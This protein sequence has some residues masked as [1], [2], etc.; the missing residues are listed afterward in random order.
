M[1]DV[2]IKSPEKIRSQGNLSK[3]EKHQRKA[4]V[5]TQKTPSITQSIADAVVIKNEN[6]FFL[7]LP[8]GHVPMEGNHGFGLY[9]N[10][11]RYLK[12]YEIK[13]ANAEM[14]LLVSDASKGFAAVFE[15]TNPEINLG[16]SN[17]IQAN[18]IGMKVERIID[19][20]ND[21]LYE[22][23]TFQNYGRETFKC[24]LSLQF[25]ADFNDIFA[26]RGLLEQHLGEVEAPAFIEDS[27]RFCYHGADG[28]ERD[29]DVRFSP[30]PDEVEDTKIVFQ[31]DLEPAETKQILV[32]LTVSEA[33]NPDE[34]N[35]KPDNEPSLQGIT[36]YLKR[37]S[38]EWLE[39]H[40]HVHSDSLLLNQ[41]I[42][43]SLRDLR[44]LRNNLDEEEYFAA[45]VPWFTTLFGRDS[46]ITA[47]ETLAY[48]PEIAAE[49]LKLLA[50]YQ[51]TQIDE[52]RDEQ[53]GKIL[54]EIR[55]GELA[56]LGEIPHTP[57]YGSV[58]ATPLFLILIA[59]HADWVGNLDLFNELQESV[60]S[61]LK[62]LT[63]YATGENGFIQYHSASKNGLVNQG[64]KDSGNAIINKDG[65]LA[66]PPIA[67]VEVQGYAYMAMK[68]IA[69]LYNRAGDKAR[70]DFL[71]K[72]AQALYQR[73]N[74]AFWLEDLGYYA[75]A[76]Q[77][78][79]RPCAVV[80]SNPGEALWTGIIEPKYAKQTADRLLAEDMFSGWGVRTLSE[81]EISYNPLGYHLGTVWPHDNALIAAGLRNYGF[82]KQA[83]K[84]FVGIV[85][86][87]MQI[88]FYR[89]PELFAGF[90]RSDY[91]TIVNYPVACHPQ[92]WSAGSIPFLIQEFLGLKP[93]AFEQR[94]R[95]IRP[96]LP[97]FVDRIE[98]H[99]LRVGGAI[100]DLSFERTS[101]QRVAFKILNIK[102]TLDII[103][104]DNLSGMENSDSSG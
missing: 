4:R 9:Y 57:Y 74:Q 72:K 16:E 61:A 75:L 10:D 28:Y 37:V 67:L 26:I 65:S 12:G 101:D 51:G 87:A 44:M 58:D 48:N 41:I 78:D 52:W 95:I 20:E 31:L 7:S 69:R 33:K 27:L 77:A 3:E 97:D 98:L 59:K 6:L 50:K 102:G 86:A 21:S 54:H 43:R 68:A 89:L 29:L 23:I 22:W 79:D 24:P 38:D 32:S 2:G 100:A 15:L 47:L 91:N 82:D 93:D 42:E 18:D 88:K 103:L 85:E 1:S 5:L 55:V 17:H 94:L 35:S 83:F 73:F 62:W 66:K 34:E 8:N 76:L 46:A 80:A 71:R 19:S 81:K 96:A 25:N 40:T 36:E 104:S 60:E 39:S 92:A 14:N 99:G 90:S 70:G 45:G 64:W 13:L 53:P 63:D 56:R 11:C 49:T 30:E 84:I